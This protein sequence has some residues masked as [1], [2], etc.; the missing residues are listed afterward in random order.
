MLALGGIHSI[1]T[2]ARAFS[3]A[4]GGLRAA[5]QMHDVL[6]QKVISA[7]ITFFDRNPRGRILN[8]WKVS[9]THLNISFGVEVSVEVSSWGDRS[10]PLE[11]I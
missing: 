9:K 6:L 5:F 4:Y 10:W 11:K 2:F 8:R 3:F 1:L 7:P